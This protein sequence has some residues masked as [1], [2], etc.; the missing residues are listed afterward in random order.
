MRYSFSHF[1]KQTLLAGVSLLTL[2]T[3]FSKAEAAFAPDMKAV[4]DVAA[5]EKAQTASSA[6]QLVQ[7]TMGR[8][9]FSSAVKGGVP[10]PV[11]MELVE[12][13]RK[14]HINFK[15]LDRSDGFAILMKDGKV[16]GAQISFREKIYRVGDSQQLQDA[17][18]NPAAS[19]T[20]APAPAVT[21]PAPVQTVSTPEPSSPLAA[22]GLAEPALEAQSKPKPPAP[23]V[24]KEEAAQEKPARKGKDQKKKTA[25]A[26]AQ[27]EVTTPRV[28]PLEAK[29][30][31]LHKGEGLEALLLQRAGIVSRQEVR[32]A[33]GKIGGALD[34]ASLPEG[35]KIDVV[36]RQGVLQSFSFV[37]AD[38]GKMGSA[39][40]V[41]ERTALGGFRLR[42]DA[43]GFTTKLVVGMGEIQH[44]P[45]TDLK[46][47]GARGNEI[48]KIA[49]EL[50]GSDRL[51]KLPK[52]SGFTFVMKRRLAPD[53]TVLASEP[54]YI[55]IGGQEYLF[56][57][58]AGQKTHA[59]DLAGEAVGPVMIVPVK[60][61]KT[62]GFGWRPDP[63][64]PDHMQKHN[65]NDIAA[66]I[67]SAVVAMTRGRIVESGTSAE[68]G[69][70]LVVDCGG[71]LRFKLLH[72]RDRTF[73]PVGSMVE[74]GQLIAYVGNTG[75]RTTGPHTHVRVEFMGQPRDAEEFWNL[76]K[77]TGPS[78]Q[79]LKAKKRVI[80]YAI[81][82]AIAEKELKSKYQSIMIQDRQ[83]QML[84]GKAAGE[85]A[86]TQTIAQG[87][88]LAGH[89]VTLP[90]GA[91][92]NEI[93]YAT[94]ARLT[95]KEALG[96]KADDKPSYQQ[97]VAQIRK[98][99]DYQAKVDAY[100]DAVAARTKYPTLLPGAAP[101]AVTASEDKMPDNKTLAAL[102]VKTDD[103]TGIGGPL[104][105]E[106]TILSVEKMSPSLEKPNSAAA[107]GRHRHHWALRQ[108]KN[109][110]P[111]R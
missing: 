46:Q 63:M 6:V 4:K 94:L 10:A 77:L 39:R 33:L 43:S 24:K 27:D 85:A 13:F 35:L 82:A 101:L 17:L 108:H 84:K 111:K 105:D 98:E 69:N 14:Q 107:H 53:G 31:T 50:S 86:L 7:G 88:K 71:G 64:N 62:S 19:E 106:G 103:L 1:L 60:G 67:G 28:A 48:A 109:V 91:L 37:A 80:D 8:A 20:P 54:A 59:Y 22:A 9:F 81:Q 96:Q 26:A 100:F 83:A 45:S 61:V 56:A 87:M 104:D 79:A 34:S 76:A 44:N 92:S 73:L 5:V 16:V 58:F 15:H 89:G 25:I 68:G 55:A 52:G 51:A 90:G 75:I 49:L 110:A 2:A 3:P 97:L 32:K 23:A 66:P 95:G 57:R 21:P 42:K 38:K 65:G 72:L 30:Y 40:Y 70:F 18:Y 11:V 93:Y 29:E 41:I 36:Q 74:Q 99:K 102:G 78:L 47:A 12:E